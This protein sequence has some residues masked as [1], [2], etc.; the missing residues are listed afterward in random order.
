MAAKVATY[1]PLDQVTRP[2][3]TTEEIA[4]YSNSAPQ[5]WRLH[6]CRGTG[7]IRPRRIPG[8]ARLYWP[9]EAVRKML[10]VAQ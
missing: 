5:T 9:T 3:L 8:L 2:N 10:G 7:P 1:P 6:A 4:Y